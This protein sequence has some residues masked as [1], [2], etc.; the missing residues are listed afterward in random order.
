V[1]TRADIAATLQEIGSSRDLDPTIRELRRLGW[2]RALRVSGVWAFLPPGEA[3][4]IDRYIDLRGWMARDSDAIFALAGEAA[5]WHLG[6]LDRAYRGLVAIWTPTKSRLPHGLRSH[7][8]TVTLGF[9][10]T[11]APRLGPSA[12]L[13]RRR[14]L[15]LQSWAGGLPGLGPEAL[16]VQLAARPSSF[17]AWGDLVSHLEQIAEDCDLDRLT[18]LLEGQSSSAWQRAGYLLHCGHRHDDGVAL[19]DHRSKRALPKV[20]FGTGPETLWVAPFAIAD[21]LIAPLQR[22]AGKA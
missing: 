9:D 13:L 12:T 1:V 19:L 2:L 8:T 15:D 5:A 11:D 17:R 22:S 21:H 20:Q 16:I 10:A 18:R 7:V 14:R 6:Y 4:I 3:E